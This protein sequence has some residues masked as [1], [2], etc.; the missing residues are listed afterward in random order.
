MPDLAQEL[1]SVEDDL[2][3]YRQLISRAAEWIH[4]PA[5]DEDARAALAQ[6]LGLPG[7]RAA[8]ASAP[9][10]HTKTRSRTE[11]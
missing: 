8:V 6:R 7:P 5:Y 4:D 1:R 3:R 10:T 11:P 9:S 2:A